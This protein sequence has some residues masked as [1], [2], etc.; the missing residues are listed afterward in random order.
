MRAARGQTMPCSPRI[1]IASPLPAESAFIADS[2]SPEGFEPFRLT[3]QS[4]LVAELQENAFDL[5][6][7]DTTLA[8]P[9]I[10]AVRAR[11]PLTPII[12]VGPADSIAESQ[13]I[14]RGVVYLSRPLDRG[15]FVCTIAMAIMETRPVRRSERKGARFAAVVQGV[16]SL[17]IDVS[18]EGMRLEIPRTRNAAP[19]RPLF[20]VTVPMLGVAVNVRRLWTASPP[21]SSRDAIW[22]GS[23]LTNN[24]RRV[25]QAWLTLVEAL[26]A[27]SASLEMQ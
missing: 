6:V 13:A 12:V 3:N 10:N 11:S 18:K 24:S 22:Y 27:S 23:E 26:P 25:E 16:P 9:A 19:P 20:G 15:L 2:L 14:A 4:R 8:T 21:E 1:A 7:V 17:M 5:L